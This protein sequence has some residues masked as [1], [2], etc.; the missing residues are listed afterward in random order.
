MNILIIPEDFKKDQYML[1]PIIEGMM[2]AIGK[3]AT[4]RVCQDPKLGGVDQALRLERI[5]E[6]VDKYQYRVDLF[7]L[8]IDRDGKEGRRA[9]LDDLESRVKAEKNCVLMGEN[10]WQEIEVWVLAGCSGFTKSAADWK[11]TVRTEPHPKDIF[12]LPYARERGLLGHLEQGRQ[13]LGQEAG[14]NYK[15]VRQLCP[16]LRELQER[17]ERLL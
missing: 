4:V 14:A 3:K 7:L 10:A 11:K 1:K 5:V 12:Y 2:K 15:R 9:I 8:C 13:K 17:I 16:E 6:V